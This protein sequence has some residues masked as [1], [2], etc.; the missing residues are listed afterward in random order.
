MAER[1]IDV[2]AARLGDPNLGR[3]HK[4]HLYTLCLHWPGFEQQLETY[5]NLSDPKVKLNHAME[6]RDNVEFLCTGAMY[7][8][9]LRKLIPIFFKLLEGPP[10]FISTSWIQVWSSLEYVVLSPVGD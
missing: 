4:P 8:V 9:F 3:S 1:N 5:K 6:L 10:I 7:P 2:F